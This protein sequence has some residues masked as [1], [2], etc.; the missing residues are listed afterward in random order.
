MINNNLIYIGNTKNKN[1]RSVGQPMVFLTLPFLFNNP[2][3]SD[4]NKR[5][6]MLIVG[7]LIIN[8]NLI[9]IRQG[10]CRFT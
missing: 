8:L 3:T 10:Y 1:L 9:K 5:Q 4:N 7:S 6:T 2:A